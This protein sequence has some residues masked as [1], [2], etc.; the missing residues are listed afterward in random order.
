VKVTDSLNAA[1]PQVRVYFTTNG[2][3]TLAPSSALADANGFA[4]VTATAN[5]VVGSYQVGAIVFDTSTEA[6]ITQLFNLTN[7]AAIPTFALTVTKSGTGSGTVTATG[8]GCGV[9]CNETYAQGTVVSL[10]AVPVAGSTF[11]GWSGGGCSGIGA[12]MVTMSAAQTVN[13]QFDVPVVVIAHPVPTLHP[14]M[15]ALLALLAAVLPGAVVR[16][17]H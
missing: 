16:R 4:E 13:A 6:P 2:N 1:T 15:L 17:K 11:V 3:A 10:A 12:C 9:D 8:V 14:L 7:L 5:G